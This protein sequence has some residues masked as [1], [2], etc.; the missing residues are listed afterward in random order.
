[1]TVDTDQFKSLAIASLLDIDP[2]PTIVLDLLLPD[3]QRIVY[4]NP[5]FQVV[6]YDVGQEISKLGVKN[7]PEGALE[8]PATWIDRTDRLWTTITLQERWILSSRNSD[9][10]CAGARP[11]ASALDTSE[12]LLSQTQPSLVHIREPDLVHVDRNNTKSDADL[13]GLTRFSSEL[14]DFD[15]LLLAIPWHS[16]SL[17]SII[18][19]P[20]ALLQ[21]VSFMLRNSEPRLLIWG[22]ERILI[23]NE[24]CAPVFGLKHP[25]ALGARTFDIWAEL[26]G[27]IAPSVTSAIDEGLGSKFLEMPIPF[28]RHGFLEECFFNFGFVTIVGSD[29]RG[30]GAFDEFIEVSKAVIDRRRQQTIHEIN[31]LLKTAENL[32]DAWSRFADG[33]R[34][35][36]NDIPYAIFYSVSTPTTSDSD[37]TSSSADQLL[38]PKSATFQVSLGADPEQL[39][40]S[41][42]FTVDSSSSSPLVQ[43]IAKAQS[44]GTLVYMQLSDGTLPQ[45]L[46]IAVP[47]RAWND[48]IKA[49]C[50]VP[51]S[52]TLRY[53]PAGFAVLGVNP[54]Q[55]ID[56]RMDLFFNVLSDTFC[57]MVT[58]VSLPE[59]TRRQKVLFQDLESTLTE[60]VKAHALQSE[61][62]EARFTRMAHSAPIGM[63][64]RQTV[65]CTYCLSAN[66]S[67]TS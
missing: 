26:E 55:A 14:T 15:R 23:Y 49:I 21:A 37:H 4:Q 61:R 65:I 63:V 47:D 52:S 44:S 1:M 12:R 45:E 30:N 13:L 17:G 5:A 22:P 35:N 25:A 2:R 29:H 11:N 41:R 56:E 8:V 62:L 27:L 32:E 36:V 39:G 51:F 64:R 42:Y 50:I 31:S 48:K 10:V 67:S 6:K 16:T 58:L 40:L 60:R 19:W 43:A 20:V 9:L 28:M 57:T 53:G 46:E 33:L 3:D 34:S 59:Q 54:R 66:I 7:T 24:A 18:T 38:E